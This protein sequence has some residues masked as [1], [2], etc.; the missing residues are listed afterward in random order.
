MEKHLFFQNKKKRQEEKSIV[1]KT[2][3]KSKV[4]INKI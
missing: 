3:E 2:F 1:R 4:D